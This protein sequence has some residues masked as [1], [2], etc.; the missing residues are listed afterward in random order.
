MIKNYEQEN[1]LFIFR[2]A[3]N[4][5]VRSNM[6][7]QKEKLWKNKKKNNNKKMKKNENEMKKLIHSVYYMYANIFD[8]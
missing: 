7:Y 1:L 3:P 4:S 5:I 8:K 6:S 2:M